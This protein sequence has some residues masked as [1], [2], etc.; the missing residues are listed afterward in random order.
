MG[1]GFDLG[2]W[3][4]ARA[5]FS[6]SLFLSGYIVVIFVVVGLAQKGARDHPSA[7]SSWSSSLF[8]SRRQKWVTWLWGSVQDSS[9]LWPDVTDGLPNEQRRFGIPRT[10]QIR[11]NTSEGERDKRWSVGRR[12]VGR[13]SSYGKSELWVEPLSGF[14]VGSGHTTE[15]MMMGAGGGPFVPSFLGRL[16]TI[17]DL[18]WLASLWWGKRTEHGGF[19]R[20]LGRHQ[21]FPRPRVVSLEADYTGTTNL[22][23][24]G[25]NPLGTSCKSELCSRSLRGE[26]WPKEAPKTKTQ[27]KESQEREAEKEEEKREAQSFVFNTHG[28]EPLGFHSTN[29]AR[30]DASNP[31]LGPENRV[32]KGKKSAWQPICQWPIEF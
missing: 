23:I 4:E 26:A 11:E 1:L 29:Q 8:L 16:V 5:P 7:S 9:P 15:M 18:F 12:S 32:L 27:S 24:S 6:L 28:A 22:F 31:N 20:S 3:I 21:A 19:S 14:L 2:R 25:Q 17:P 30:N 13:C 10:E